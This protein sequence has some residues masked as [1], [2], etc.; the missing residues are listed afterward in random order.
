MTTTFSDPDVDY[1]TAHFDLPALRH[2]LRR[3]DVHKSVARNQGNF[4]DECFFEDYIEVVNVAIQRV[5]AARPTPVSIPGKI[6][7]AAI[8]QASD[9]VATVERYITLKKSGKNFAGL[10]LFHADKKTPS[11]T[12]YTE[13]QSWYC[14]GCGRGGD[15]FDFIMLAESCDIKRAADIL[16]GKRI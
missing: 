7:F 1:L 10:C 6:D 5:L 9:I 15:V 2:E 12:I 16:G 13:Q 8:K 3:A 11:L 4:E 14:F